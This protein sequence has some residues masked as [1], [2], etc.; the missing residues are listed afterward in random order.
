MSTDL[1]TQDQLQEVILSGSEILQKSELRVSKALSVGA[2]L[3]NEIQEKGMSPEMDE[4]ANKFLVN[5]RNAKSDIEAQRKPITSF[6]DTIRKQFTELESKLDPKVTT[7][8]SA[9]IQNFRNE[10]VKKLRQEEEE[11]NRLAQAKLDKDN[12]IIEIKSSLESQLSKY[13][14]DYIFEQKQKLQSSFNGITVENF[15]AKSKSL[16]GLCIH[17]GLEHFNAFSPNYPRRHVTQEETSI[18]LDEFL[19]S[20]DFGL[21][22][23]VVEKDLKDFVTELID[24]LP[25]LKTSLD[26]MAKAGEEEQKRLAAEKAQREAD[27]AAKMKADAD[28][29]A[30]A[31]AEELER[32]K[33]AEQTNAM[34]ENTV[35]MDSVAPETRDG[36]KLNILN[37]SG[38]AEVFTFWL[39]NDGINLTIEEMEKKSIAQM[40]AFCEKVGH[41]SGN[42]IV[43][44]NVA[45]EPVYKAV[46]RK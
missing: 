23:V 3:I 27:A 30:K 26:E 39:Q 29:K 46:N 42:M 6:F 33:V 21:I 12:E 22:K 25:S 31:D 38:I 15:E 40:K 11:K 20:K 37:I 2:N 14:Q 41:K 28:A 44:G 36:F 43:S 18:L 4:R 24:K 17:Y 13:V 35:L 9:Q 1:A 10:Y 34:M 45:Y 7:G 16:K 32:K 5:C 8:T 19:K